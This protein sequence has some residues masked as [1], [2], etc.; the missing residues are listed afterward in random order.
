MEKL[1]RLND[2]Y[3][4]KNY[5][6]F[7]GSITEFIQTGSIYVPELIEINK[8][9]SN[10]QRVR[11]EHLEYLTELMQEI[12]PDGAVNNFETNLFKTEQAKNYLEFLNS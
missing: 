5:G 6:F 3:P 11:I 7:R 10:D 8:P 2:F 9:A 12:F 4:Y 1:T